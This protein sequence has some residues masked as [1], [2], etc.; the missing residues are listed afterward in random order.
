[1]ASADAK[2]QLSLGC[3]AAI[4]IRFSRVNRRAV[5]MVDR[6]KAT[7]LDQRTI[8]KLLPIRVYPSQQ[9]VFVDKENMLVEVDSRFKLKEMRKKDS[10]QQNIGQETPPSP[11]PDQQRVRHW[12]HYLSLSF[13]SLGKL[14]R[15]W[16]RNSYHCSSAC[17]LPTSSQADPTLTI[18]RAVPQ[19]T[20]VVAPTSFAVPI[21]EGNASH[22]LPETTEVVLIEIER[23]ETC[24]ICLSEYVL[25]DRIRLLPCGHEYHTEC[26]DVWLCRKST[27]CP[28]CKYDLL[29]DIPSISKEQHALEVQS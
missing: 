6:E 21:Q 10:T 12:Q 29:N 19:T 15:L 23:E 17:N 18:T 2:Q 3:L 5:L 24:S 28:L 16:S 26:V 7:T 20:E 1:M 13:M 8:N 11:L 22:A 14:G 27:H 25:D 9:L 4:I